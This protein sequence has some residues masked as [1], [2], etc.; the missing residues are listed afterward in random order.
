MCSQTNFGIVNMNVY[1][2]GRKLQE[3]IHSGSDMTPE[4]AFI[5]L[6][7]LL[8]NEKKNIKKLISTNLRGEINLRIKEEFLNI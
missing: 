2:T 4:T 6:V 5:K 3:F 7:W 1:G 8:S